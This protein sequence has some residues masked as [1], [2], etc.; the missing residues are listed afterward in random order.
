MFG[1]S[2]VDPRGTGMFLW[3]LGFWCLL[4]VPQ[5]QAQFEGQPHGDDLKVECDACHS[6]EGWTPLREPL[7]FQH[8][9]TG[10]PLLG[11]HADTGCLACHED[12]V[13]SNVE[14]SCFTCH[15]EEAQQATTPDHTNLPSTCEDC[16]SAISWTPASFDHNQTAFPLLGAHRNVD[17]EDCH[18]DGYTGTPVDC[19]SCHETDFNGASDPSHDGFPTTCED[20]HRET[21]WEPASFDHNQTAFPLRGAHRNTDCAD[22]HADGYAGTPVD[23]FSCHESDY[24]GASDPSHDGFPTTC[25]DC[26][27]ESAWEPASFD[28]NQTAFPLRGAHRNTDCADCH[29]DGYAGTPTDCFSCHESDYDGATDPSHDGFPTTCEDCH[30]ESAWEPASFDH[31]QTAFPLRGAHRNTDCADCHADGY[32]GTPTACFSCHEVDYDGAADPNH[33]GFPTTCEDCH[34]ETAWEP[35]DFDHNRTA[36]PLRGEHR[37]VDCVECHADGYSGT[38]IDCFSCHQ[39]DYD[40]AN[41]PDHVSAGFPTTCEQCHNEN[42]WNDTDWDHDGLYFPIY[43]GS[44]RGEWNVCE[45]CHV[46]PGNFRVFECIFCHEHNQPDMDDEHDDVSGYSYDSRSCFRCHPDGEE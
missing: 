24:D 17:C 22:C 36:F 25:E 40:R 39:E 8:E 44:H 23:C 6:V 30:G 20:C 9:V 43:S 7:S 27:G 13:F 5:T 46:S 14:T 32:A 10:F 37:N 18:A 11:A 2:G 3:A 4:V 42:D 31:N 21:S 16:H 28:H 29:A 1:A 26:H 33:D 19:F 35:A 45:D 34:S 12:L 41:N 15:A 38:P